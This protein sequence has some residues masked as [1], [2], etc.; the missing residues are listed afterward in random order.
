[1]IATLEHE[2][3]RMAEKI[4]CLTK[5]HRAIDEYLNAVSHEIRAS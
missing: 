2:R 1:M 4:V 5:N 3:D